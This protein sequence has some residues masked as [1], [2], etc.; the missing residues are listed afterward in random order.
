VLRFEIELTRTAI[1]KQ[2][3]R[4]GERLSGISQGTGIPSGGLRSGWRALV[5][6]K[7]RRRLARLMVLSNSFHV[8]SSPRR[9]FGN[10]LAVRGMDSFMRKEMN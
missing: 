2:S 7:R 4:G 5:E 10:I 3:P 1:A 9:S 8:L 6:R